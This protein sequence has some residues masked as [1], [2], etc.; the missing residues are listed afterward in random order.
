[1]KNTE[2]KNNG[3]FLTLEGPDASGK[4]TALPYLAELLRGVGYK[5][6]ITRE[7][8]G[9]ELAEEIRALLLS[10]P[11]SG[12]TECLLFAAAR[13]DHVETVI[14]SKLQAG[15]IVLSD[16]FHD[17]TYAY[18]AAGRGFH[19]EVLQMEEFVLG[20]FQPDCTL[21][22]MVGYETSRDRLAQRTGKQDRLDQ[23]T[24]AF[25]RRVYAGYAERLASAGARAHC[26]NAEGDIQSVRDQ[27]A[28]WVND[29]LIPRIDSPTFR[30][31]Q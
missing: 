11:M 20:D 18:Q 14:R 30:K 19:K 13:N 28:H 7:P 23:E 15:Y 27:I 25:K 31:D 6:H 21:F 8:G 10:R 9:S 17:S 24:E 12:R 22:F 4:S 29:V 26:I 16:R 1:M 3:F 2:F 5:V